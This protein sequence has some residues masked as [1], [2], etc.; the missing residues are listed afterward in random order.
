M[1]INKQLLSLN[2]IWFT[3]ASA[4]AEV[5]DKLLTIQG[6]WGLAFAIGIAFSVVTFLLA[7]SF[8]RPWLAVAVVCISLISTLRPAIEPDIAEFAKLEL[9]T[10]YLEHA[11]NAE[12]VQTL[13]ATIGLLTGLMIR[14]RRL[15]AK[16][17]MQ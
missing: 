2:F 9:G 12:W 15:K 14:R 11:E 7:Y 1:T 6:L 4:Y 8:R 13:F 5:S 10:N 16:G 3:P 17:K